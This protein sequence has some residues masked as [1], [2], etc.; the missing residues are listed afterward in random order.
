MDI[1][2]QLL[3]VNTKEHDCW[4]IWLRVSLVLLKTSKLFHT[5]AVIILHSHQQCFTAHVALHLQQHLVL[6]V[7]HSLEIL[8]GVHVKHAYLPCVYLL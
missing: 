6:S 1:N 5:V 3:W 4:I 2:F 7:F 8:I